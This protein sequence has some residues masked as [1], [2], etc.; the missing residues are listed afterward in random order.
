MNRSGHDVRI[1][2]V[3]PWGERPPSVVSRRAKFQ[4]ATKSAGWATANPAVRSVAPDNRFLRAR[5]AVIDA[6]A[7][8]SGPMQAARDALT[9]AGLRTACANPLLRPRRN[10]RAVQPAGQHAPATGRTVTDRRRARR[11]GP[12]S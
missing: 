3:Y 10:R 5:G 2:H 11:R 8:P 7:L 1:L 12:V 9:E 4:A 6:V